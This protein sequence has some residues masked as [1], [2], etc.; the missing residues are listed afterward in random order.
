LTATDDPDPKD[1]AAGADA[2][3]AERASLVV[4]PE[5]NEWNLSRVARLLGVTRMTIYNRLR[6]LGVPRER[7][8]KSRPPGG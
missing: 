6:R 1:V 5:R 2:E 8:L 3:E 7:T 4:M